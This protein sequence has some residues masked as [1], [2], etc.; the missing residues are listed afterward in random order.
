M[1]FQFSWRGALSR[2]PLGTIRV[3]LVYLI[4]RS[5]LLSKY[6]IMAISATL[7]SL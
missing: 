3:D 1:A 2:A 5:L 6:E 7:L 4:T